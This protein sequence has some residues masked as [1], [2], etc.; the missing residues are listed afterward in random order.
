[1]PGSSDEDNHQGTGEEVQ[2]IPGAGSKKLPGDEQINDR[3]GYREN[4]ADQAL[5]KQADAK[6]HRAEQSPETRVAFNFVE[7]AQK[8]PERKGDRPGSGGHPV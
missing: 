6:T 1:M 5:G 4:Q 7:C 8:R 2:A 3:D